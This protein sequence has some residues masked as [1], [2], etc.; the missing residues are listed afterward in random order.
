[1][2]ESILTAATGRMLLL[3]MFLEEIA[4]VIFYAK[5]TVIV[6]TMP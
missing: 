3:A 1:M 6:V 2:L 5:F 4:T